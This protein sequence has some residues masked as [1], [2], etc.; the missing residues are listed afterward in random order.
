MKI[1]LVPD[2]P[3]WAFDRDADAV[4][5]YLPQYDISKKFNRKVR[6]SD[7]KEYDLVHFMNWS[8]GAKFGSKVSCGVSSHNHELRP[9]SNHAKKFPQF[10]GMIATSQKLYNSIK[11][12]NVNSFCAQGGVHEDIF[13]PNVRNESK[14]V[15]G[16]VGQAGGPV[17]I[18]GYKT[19]L[20]PLMAALS[21]Y[22]DIEF[23]VLSN[24][25]KKA[26]PYSK[27]PD[28]YKDIDVQLCTSKAEGAPNPMFEAASSA[29]ALISTD[30]GAISECIQEG[31]N[32]Y[33]VKF[34]EDV[35]LRLKEKI[36]CLY[37]DRSL[38]LQMG[39]EG[40]KIIE[41]DWTW[42]KR[43]KN[44]IPFFERMREMN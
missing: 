18:K 25:Y 9:E 43:V 22:K 39:Q 10:K 13:L 3:N 42:K 19:Y 30:V 1:L 21:E 27:M 17:D 35:V 6:Q 24:T 14:F 2:V 16:W 15:I 33:L 34:D 8:E 40:R 32:G 4:I 44:W 11:E 28:F 23:K 41:K 12:Y 26:Q 29:K 20:E 31:V 38:C 37:R 5:K 36:L 7:F